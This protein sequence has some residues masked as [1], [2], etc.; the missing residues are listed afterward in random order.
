MPQLQ[1]L[2]NHCISISLSV[3]GN[4]IALCS[5]PCSWQEVSLDVFD[6]LKNDFMRPAINEAS[7]KQLILIG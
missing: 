1:N 4:P 2:K 5:A 6:A 7:E 3:I